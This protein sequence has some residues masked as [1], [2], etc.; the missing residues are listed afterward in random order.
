MHRRVPNAAS[1][2]CYV[3]V[4]IDC[5]LH[6]KHS[7]TDLLGSPLCCW[8]WW[9]DLNY[10]GSA[11]TARCFN[12]KDFQGSFGLTAQ[13]ELRIRLVQHLAEKGIAYIGQSPDRV[14][15]IQKK[16]RLGMPSGDRHWP[17]RKLDEEDPFRIAMQFEL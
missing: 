15:P 8:N 1:T 12:I 9:G 7:Y 10:V 4:G 3:S 11:S 13:F 5:E 6:L 17:Y 16:G 2:P 14:I